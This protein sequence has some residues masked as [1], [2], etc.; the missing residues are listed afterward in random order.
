VANI[1]IHSEPDA[2]VRIVGDAH[3]EAGKLI[4]GDVDVAAKIAS[5]MGVMTGGRQLGF[6]EATFTKITTEVTTSSQSFDGKF[7]EVS[8]PLATAGGA[9]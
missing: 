4:V 8:E 3:F 7:A 1:P 9:G 2:I 6:F 5:A